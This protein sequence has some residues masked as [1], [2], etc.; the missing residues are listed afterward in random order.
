MFRGLVA[1]RRW[2]SWAVGARREQD[3][4]VVFG[5]S[6]QGK[7]TMGVEMESFESIRFRWA[8][9]EGAEEEEY[10][11][12]VIDVETG[13]EPDCFKVGVYRCGGEEIDDGLFAEGKRGY[14]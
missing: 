5:R 2:H 10:T 6:G 13:P 14:G 7:F 8:P 9:V 4:G 3:E 1:S 12:T 11:V